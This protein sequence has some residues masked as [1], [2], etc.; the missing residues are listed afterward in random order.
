MP[1]QSQQQKWGVIPG[2]PQLPPVIN[3]MQ[4]RE[5]LEAYFV[6]LRHGLSYTSEAPGFGATY[7]K[8]THEGETSYGKGG[9]AKKPAAKKPAAKKPA[10][11]KPAAKK[12]A[13]KK[14]VAKKKPATKKK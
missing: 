13:A 11:K 12:T 9:A 8:G 2:A 6:P 4:R 10:A 7:K 3:H 14:T 1:P 5:K